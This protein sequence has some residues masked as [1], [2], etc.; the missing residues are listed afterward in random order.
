MKEQSALDEYLYPR[1]TQ[2]LRGGARLLVPQV[3][4]HGT[5]IPKKV[6]SKGVNVTRG[7]RL[8]STWSDIVWIPP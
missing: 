7:Q 1:L 4:A 5:V 3:S 6:G 8:A 2:R